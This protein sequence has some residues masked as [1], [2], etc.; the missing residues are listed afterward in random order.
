[1]P[2]CQHENRSLPRYNKI[3]GRKTAHVRREEGE[4]GKGPSFSFDS[5][6]GSGKNIWHSSGEKGSKKR[7]EVGKGGKIA[8]DARKKLKNSPISQEPLEGA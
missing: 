5:Q 4:R 3:R 7:S 2:V 8:G 6:F 1:M